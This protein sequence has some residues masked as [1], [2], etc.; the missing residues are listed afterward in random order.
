MVVGEAKLLVETL[1]ECPHKEQSND[2]D[3]FPH[4]LNNKSLTQTL[5]FLAGS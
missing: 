1:S 3:C 5:S 4:E 2:V